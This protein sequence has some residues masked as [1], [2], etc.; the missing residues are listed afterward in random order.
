VAR[1]LLDSD[2]LI[3]VLRGKSQAVDFVESLLKDEVPAISVL[4]IY[5]VWSGC[6]PN[7]EEAVSDL[8][9]G[10]NVFP[11]TAEIARQ[12]A[13]YCRTFRSK[14]VTLSTA[15]ALIAATAQVSQLVLVTQNQRDFPMSDFEK[16]SL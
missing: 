12:A 5:E 15:D 4:S 2:V 9:D 13:D 10:F 11:V 16:K 6:K 3:W 8:L 1:H 14:G 7:E